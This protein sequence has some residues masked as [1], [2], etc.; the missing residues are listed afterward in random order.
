MAQIWSYG[1]V[2][3]HFLDRETGKRVVAVLKER[4]YYKESHK[5]VCRCPRHG[6][7]PNDCG[8]L[9]EANEIPEEMNNGRES[10]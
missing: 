6:M 4:G 8:C 3:C 5:V 10:K 2:E 1:G 7:P 9:Q